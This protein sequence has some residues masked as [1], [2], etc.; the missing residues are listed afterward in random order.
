ME[1]DERFRPS[2]ATPEIALRASSSLSMVV[3]A[4]ERRS[5]PTNMAMRRLSQSQ[6]PLPSPSSAKPGELAGRAILN[7]ELAG[8]RSLTRAS[9]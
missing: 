3:P 7:Q 2:A 8:S 6:T 4:A 1:P 5:L 9:I